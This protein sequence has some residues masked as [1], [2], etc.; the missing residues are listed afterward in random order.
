MKYKK[1]ILDILTII[2][3][4]ILMDNTITGVPI[5][6]ILGISI[7]ILF[8]IHKIF[9]W[10]WIKNITLNLFSKKTPIKTKIMY[11]L[12]FLLLVLIILNT[13]SGIFISQTLFTY[14][15]A[16]NIS[17]W[18]HLH[19]FFA[20]SFLVVI[21][22][23]L[24]LH[25]QY[26]MNIFKKILKIQKTNIIIKT[27]LRII[28]LVIATLGITSLLNPAINKNFI[29]V[30]KTKNINETTNKIVKKEVIVPITA[31]KTITL[32]EFLGNIHCTG[33]NRRCPLTS[34]QCVI[35][36]TYREQKIEEYNL[37]NQEATITEIAVEEEPAVE[38][39]TESIMENIKEPNIINY[40][41]ILGLF[42]GGTYYISKIPKKK[43]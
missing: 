23:H 21:A 39:T 16:Q 35:G 12:D 36:E 1:I 31:E 26:I 27:I 40:I 43:K 13:L 10:A 2:I 15:N 6:E 19:H 30:P 7:L 5:H 37:N 11:F 25:W 14:L 29:P 3:M 41:S 34:P 24:G 38:K 8:L 32:E 18:S 22:I 20:Y 17:L 4:I 28:S 42:V 33:C 9:N